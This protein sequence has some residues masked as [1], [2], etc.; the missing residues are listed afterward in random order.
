MRDQISEFKAKY[1][2]ASVFVVVTHS[3]VVFVQFR[4]IVAMISQGNGVVS[5]SVPSTGKVGQKHGVQRPQEVVNGVNS[6]HA[7]EKVVKPDRATK[8]LSFKEHP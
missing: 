6:G 7:R 3:E 5:E 4:L 2:F 8:Y 1:P